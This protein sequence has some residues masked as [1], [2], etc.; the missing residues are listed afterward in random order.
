M[1]LTLD[2]LSLALLFSLGFSS[3]S[4][5]TRDENQFRNSTGIYFGSVYS[6]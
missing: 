3:A 1:R 5:I 6:M 4:R 2:S